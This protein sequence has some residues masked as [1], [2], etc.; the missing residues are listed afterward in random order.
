[1]ALLTVNFTSMALKRTVPFN[2]ILPCDKLFAPYD[3]SKKFKT[4]YLLHG[5]L[6]NYTDWV[7]GTNI[8][9]WAQERDLCVV[10]PSGDNS[11]Y[12]DHDT[13][14]E[15]YGK[16]IGEELVEMTRRMFPLSEKKEDTFIAGLSMG[17]FGALRNG[18]DY[19]NTF[20]YIAGL[21]S[22]IHA[23]EFPEN[24]PERGGIFGELD[25]FG[26]YDEAVKTKK[27][28]RVCMEELVKKGDKSL[29]PKIFMCCGTEDHLIKAN[30]KLRDSLIENG[31]DVTW[32]EGPGQHNWDFWNEYI[33]HILNWL[34]L[35]SGTQGMNSGNVKK[36]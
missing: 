30:Y 5:L 35:E 7:T 23:F 11:F 29:F 19:Y 21:S 24:D 8:Q 27:N 1:M 6:G 28:P 22:A 20:G 17:G 33:L 15:E 25:I 34:P 16:F 32:E 3:K 9:R 10:M 18:L 13:K 26:K 2:V 4:L 31:F 12:F 36:D 14:N